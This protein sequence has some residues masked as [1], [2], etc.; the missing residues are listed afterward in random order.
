MSPQSEADAAP[1]PAPD[2]GR[3]GPQPTT[4]VYAP[5]RYPEPDWD[6]PA[7]VAE[8]YV[9]T[10]GTVGWLVRQDDALRFLSMCPPDHLGHV[11]KGA[12]RDH[13]RTGAREAI[14]AEL[15]WPV[16]LEVGL[17]T[18]VRERPLPDVLDE[19][20]ALWG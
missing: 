1:E 7:L 4:L 3:W 8:V 12:I 5:P 17:H 10:D 2:E 9:P 15:L 13:L 16:L 11:L 20:R 14:P 18:P 6:A 19:Y